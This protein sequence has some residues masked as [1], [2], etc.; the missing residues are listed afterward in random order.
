MSCLKIQLL[1]DSYSFSV[2][3]PTLTLYVQVSLCPHIRRI[4]NFVR[5][6]RTSELLCESNTREHFDLFVT[7]PAI[8]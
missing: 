4:F 8:M 5:Q 1:S 7:F 6:T 3:L 2:L